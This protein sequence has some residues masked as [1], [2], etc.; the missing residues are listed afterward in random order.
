MFT[1]GN[2]DFHHVEATMNYGAVTAPCKG[3]RDQETVDVVERQ[4]G[5]SYLRG[6]SFCGLDEQSSLK[7]TGNDVLMCDCNNALEI[8]K[9]NRSVTY[10]R[11]NES[12]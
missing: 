12:E 5:Q 6:G 3:M 11:C 10:T 8:D 2:E 7:N 9:K 1:N 4:E